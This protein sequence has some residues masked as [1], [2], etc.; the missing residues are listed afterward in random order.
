M[1]LGLVA[2]AL[3]AVVCVVFTALPF[4]REPEAVD[5]RLSALSAEQAAR[6]ELVEQRDRAFAALRELELDDR[7]GKLAPDDYRQQRA[8]LRAQAAEA[9]EA[10][11][12]R[13]RLA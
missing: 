7:T 13:G 10:L 6:L 1:S 12:R 5:D 9:L 11:E 2:A 8:L 3:L 4:L